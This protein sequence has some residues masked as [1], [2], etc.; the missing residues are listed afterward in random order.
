MCREAVVLTRDEGQVL[1]VGG[2]RRGIAVGDVKA[3][4]NEEPFCVDRQQ[5]ELSYSI[6]SCMGFQLADE[7]TTETTAAIVRINDQRPQ[8]ANVRKRLEPNAAYDGWSGCCEQEI[9]YEFVAEVCGRQP[10][11]LQQAHNLREVIGARKANLC[12]RYPASLHL[13]LDSHAL[14]A[15]LRR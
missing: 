1:Q 2:V 9:P 10:G 12:V 15:A 5:P 13:Q 3:L 8:E 7:Q 11:R 14:T 4:A 6:A